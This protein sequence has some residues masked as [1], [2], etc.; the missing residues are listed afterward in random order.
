MGRATMTPLLA[1]ERL[2]RTVSDMRG[3][4]QRLADLS[5]IPRAWLS[6][7][8]Q[9][10]VK[11]PSYTRLVTLARYLGWK[12]ELKRVDLGIPL[13]PQSQRAQSRKVKRD[14]AAFGGN[15]PQPVKRKGRAR[16][17]SPDDPQE[18]AN[19]HDSPGPDRGPQ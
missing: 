18:A 2:R 12:H 16:R 8:A 9:G 5:G 15:I 17:R 13:V 6:Q 19:V 1:V 11:D 10:V 3:E 14:L 4:Y 7:F